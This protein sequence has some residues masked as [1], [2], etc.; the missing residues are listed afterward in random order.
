[1]AARIYKLKE[2]TARLFKS[3]E[4]LG[5]KIPFTQDEINQACIEA[6]AGAEHQGWLY[7]PGGVPRQRDDGG[8]GPEHQDPCRHRRA[9]PGRPISAR[10]K[11]SKASGWTSRDW[12]RPAPDTA[13]VHAKAAGLYMICTLSKHAAEAKGY[14]DAMMLD[15][16]GYVAEATGANIFFVKDGVLHTPDRRIVSSMAS[17]ASR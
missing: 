11:S 2:H 4:T 1:M 13:P 15:Y 3:A 17:P 14:A 6:A 5:M 16:R 9:G 7:P 12:R 10:R 8:V